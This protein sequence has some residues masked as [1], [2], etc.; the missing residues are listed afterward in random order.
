MNSCAIVPIDFDLFWKITSIPAGGSLLVAYVTSLL[1]RVDELREKIEGSVGTDLEI[2]IPYLAPQSV[3][4]LLDFDVAAKIRR[5][6]M[7]FVFSFITMVWYGIAKNIPALSESGA[8]G[9]LVAA[10]TYLALLPAVYS[11]VLLARILYHLLNLYAA[12]RSS[13]SSTSRKS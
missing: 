2:G 11:V 6:V 1:T 13:Q 5:L 3:R 4:A 7:L 8:Y 9:C 12:S 10:L